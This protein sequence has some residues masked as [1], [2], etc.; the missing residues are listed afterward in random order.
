MASGRKWRNYQCDKMCKEVM[1]KENYSCKA[2]EEEE[3][4]LFERNQVILAENPK[5][6]VL[7]NINSMTSRESSGVQN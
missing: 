7:T 4:F 1:E 6:I 3:Y 2:S 5:Q